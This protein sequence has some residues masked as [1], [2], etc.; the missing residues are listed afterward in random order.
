MR[1]D[2]TLTIVRCGRMYLFG[3]PLVNGRW[4]CVVL[5]GSSGNS[6]PLDTGACEFSFGF[7]DIRKSQVSRRESGHPPEDP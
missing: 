7:S 6:A 4:S 2:L 5:V 3:A 1:D